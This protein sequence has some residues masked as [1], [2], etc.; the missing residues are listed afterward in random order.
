MKK[1]VIAAIAVL[2]AFSLSA[3]SF[4]ESYVLKS[5]GISFSLPASWE[6]KDSKMGTMFTPP[7]GDVMLIFGETEGEEAFELAMEMV[8]DV[9]EE[10]VPDLE[11]DDGTELDLNGIRAI[12]FG[13]SGT[14]DGTDV[15]V[16]VVLMAGKGES[17]AFMFSIGEESAMNK[18]ESA[19]MD[20]INSFAME[21]DGTG[22][23]SGKTKPR[24]QPRPAPQPGGS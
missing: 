5:S 12:E 13:G 19:M 18:Y 1:L 17:I 22:S 3:P 16:S 14:S 15:F 24:P 6:A 21:E 2:L 11:L 4:A 8:G 9:A 10:V 23:S 7:D 20:L